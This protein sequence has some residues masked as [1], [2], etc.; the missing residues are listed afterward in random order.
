M[1]RAEKTVCFSLFNVLRVVAG[2][3]AL[4]QIEEAMDSDLC[5]PG[6]FS[7]CAPLNSHEIIVG[8]NR[9]LK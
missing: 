1:A 5:L 4:W 7:G 3:L 6:N 8:T 9:D 2:R